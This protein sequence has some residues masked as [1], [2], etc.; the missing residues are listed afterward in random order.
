LTGKKEKFDGEKIDH[1]M[2][3]AK[4]QTKTG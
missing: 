2:A 3:N 4:T 1:V